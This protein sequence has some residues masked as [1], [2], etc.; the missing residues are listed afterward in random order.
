MF[1]FF[2]PLAVRQA[3]LDSPAIS[4]PDRTFEQYKLLVGGKSN[5]EARGIARNLLGKAVWWDWDRMLIFCVLNCRGM[6]NN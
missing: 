5:T 2:F 1:Y 6:G 3:I 4:S